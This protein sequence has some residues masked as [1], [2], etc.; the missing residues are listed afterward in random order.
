MKSINTFNTTAI[1]RSK[2]FKAYTGDIISSGR[3]SGSSGSSMS[4]EKDYIIPV[5]TYSSLTAM[6]N[7]GA[8]EVGIIYVTEDTDICY[9][10]DD[11]TNSMVKVGDSQ[12]VVFSSGT[13]TGT[14]Q[15]GRLYVD[16][17]NK[18]FY[19]WNGSSYTQVSQDAV[20]ISSSTA[21]DTT[22]NLDFLTDASTASGST[23]AYK[24]KTLVAGSNVTLTQSGSTVTI[25][26]TG[27]S[28]GTGTVT[29]VATGNGITGGTITTSGTLSV[30]RT[31]SGSGTFVT[32]VTQTANGYQV[33][34]GTPSST[35]SGVTSIATSSPISGGTITSTGTIS[36]NYDNNTLKLDGSTLEVNK[37]PLALMNGNFDSGGTWSLQNL[38]PVVYDI[39]LGSTTL[40]AGNY[41]YINVGNSLSVSNCFGIQA[42]VTKYGTG[43]AT[44]QQMK[45]VIAYP[46]YTGNSSN[47]YQVIVYNGTSTTISYL[48]IHIFF[49]TTL[50]IQ[51]LFLS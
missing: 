18:K 42:S 17:T 34:Y 7:D 38:H 31:T 45:D 51:S 27:G 22:T 8:G 10:Y 28:G 39:Y 36:L 49:W 11:S 41:Y 2:F 25:A 13:P 44:D 33:S 37:V 23:V 12:A 32:D 3:A 9:I 4:K 19:L 1:P 30:T 50:N 14:G 29:S 40:A 5:D 43:G 6:I 21:T 15:T 46:Y 24:Y 20:S 35:G 47:I 16:T 26:S 48:H